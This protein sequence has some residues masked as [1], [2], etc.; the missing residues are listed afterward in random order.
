MGSGPLA[1][2]PHPSD[3]SHPNRGVVCP[4]PQHHTPGPVATGAQATGLIID[5]KTGPQVCT[6]CDAFY[7]ELAPYVTHCEQRHNMNVTFRCPKCNI[8][9]WDNIHGALIH[10]GLCKRSHERAVVHGDGSHDPTTV[11]Y[12]KCHHCDR[13]FQ[14]RSGLGA[15]V[16]SRH[17]AEFREAANEFKFACSECD[18]KYATKIGLSQHES[19]RHPEMA[20]TSRARTKRRG[21]P[22]TVWTPKKVARLP[23][24]MQRYEGSATINREIAAAIGD[25]ITPK[26]V[27][28]KRRDILA[29]AQRQ[30]TQPVPTTLG[31][32]EPQTSNASEILVAES[33]GSENTN[34]LNNKTFDPQLWRDARL[35]A[36]PK[37]LVELTLLNLDEALNGVKPTHNA[38]ILDAITKAC[39]RRSAPKNKKSPK[40]RHLKERATTY[41]RL[42]ELW[43]SRKKEL[44][45][46]VLD[47]ETGPQQKCQLPRD[48]VTIT[49]CERFSGGPSD[50]NLTH[51][52]YSGSCESSG[53]LAPIT[54]KEVRE[55]MRNS[56]AHA[57]PG[58]DG[59]NLESLKTVNKIENILAN[60]YNSW[61]YSGTMAD[62]VK[63]CRS[64][65]LPKTADKLEDINNWRPL[66]IASIL[67][68]LY[69]ATLSSRI[70]IATK[71]D[72]RQRGFV[73]KG[74]CSENI[75]L[76]RKLEE[77]AKEKRQSYGVVFLDMAKAFDT[78]SHGHISSALRRL[79]VPEVIIGAVMNT[80]ADATTYFELATGK[81]DPIPIKRGVKQG[82]PMS[83]LLFN[84]AMDTL[85]CKLNELPGVQSPVGHMSALAYADDIAL[86]NTS[87][88]G[89]QTLL[90]EVELFTSRVGMRLNVNKS[91]GY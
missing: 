80:Y 8:V 90:D 14:S 24:L 69:T 35:T 78:V 26:Q 38:E 77:W 74:S 40:T 48:T 67:S 29:Q 64:I 82:D 66:T 79:K 72:V 13:S 11:G 50:I 84:I 34:A 27:S 45:R 86:V 70:S 39:A 55:I 41:R 51:Y 2:V 37:I 53:L 7:L 15:H 43:A 36:G 4:V 62:E 83:P 6:L 9:K 68:R 65:L 46:L 18:E 75:F 25:G 44:T 12:F 33:M 20:N 3:V 61:L 87:K 56:N 5:I 89:M 30:F 71:I 63:G 47:E 52:P 58:P 23:D 57:A 1:D 73:S 19:H 32:P 91:D 22:S 59:I 16:K 42:Q 60:W 54:P 21:A 88:K 49:Y 85:M 17:E 28:D 81:T 10:A 31:R 76:L